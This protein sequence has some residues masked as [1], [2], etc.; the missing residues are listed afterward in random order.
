M[1]CR[2]CGVARDARA[3]VQ[4][5]AELAPGSGVVDAAD[6]QYELAAARRVDHQQRCLGA[7]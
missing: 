3:D 1:P 5:R 2:G 7:V 4:V 6:P